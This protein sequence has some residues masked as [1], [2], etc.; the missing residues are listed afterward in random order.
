MKNSRTIAI[1]KAMVVW[2]MV[3][4]FSAPAAALTVTYTYDGAGRLTKAAFASGQR[5]LYF[6]DQ[7]GNILKRQSFDRGSDLYG[8]VNGDNRIGTAEALYILQGIAEMR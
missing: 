7:A 4:F 1:F 8:D 3:I 6:Y 2:A 5:I